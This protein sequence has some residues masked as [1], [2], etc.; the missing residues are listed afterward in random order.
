[1]IHLIWLVLFSLPAAA[2]SALERLCFS[3]SEEAQRAI[4]VLN[5]VLVKGHDQ[6]IPEGPCLNVNVANSRAELFQRW[7]RTRLPQAQ[8]AFSTLDAPK[9]E[10]DMVVT[11]TT[12]KSEHTKS[13]DVNG[14]AFQVSAGE[15][16]QQESERHILKVLSGGTATLRVDTSE[17]KITCTWRNSGTYLLQFSQAY[18]SPPPTSST[19]LTSERE[20]SPGQRIDL[21]QIVNDLNKE[22]KNLG[23]PSGVQVEKTEGAQTIRWSLVIQ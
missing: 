2:D 8:Y 3:S 11:K 1:M 23:I 10:C 7:V 22:Q 20:V 16:T 19:S 18:V 15:G 12:N 13:V 4:P 9:R 6:I 17:V 14:Q 5:M 21:G